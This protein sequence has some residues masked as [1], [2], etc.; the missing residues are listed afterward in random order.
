[1]ALHRG[2]RPHAGAPGRARD[3]HGPTAR[4]VSRSARSR[5]PSPPPRPRRPADADHHV[6]GR[7]DVPAVLGEPERLEPERAERREPAA[8]PGPQQRHE[9]GLRPS[10]AS[11]RGGRRA[12]GADTLIR[13][14][15][16]GKSPPGRGRTGPPPRPVPPRPR[17]APAARSRDSC[18]RPHAP[19]PGHGSGRRRRR[20]SPPVPRRRCRPGTRRRGRRP[21]AAARGSRRCRP[22][23]SVKPPSTPTPRNGRA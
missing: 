17:P 18:V 13:S 4:R 21:S 20:P 15:P 11:R 16:H 3:R 8:E 6:E 2:L 12:R 22:R 14:V 1:M 9:L 7:G 10:T 5:A 19:R 23:R